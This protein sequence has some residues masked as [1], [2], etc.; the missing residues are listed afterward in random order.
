MQTLGAIVGLAIGALI[1]V[2][3]AANIRLGI[4]LGHAFWAAAISLFLGAL[5]AGAGA[6]LVRAPLPHLLQGV[7]GPWW[8]WLGGAIG[9]VFVMSAIILI[10]R[11]GAAMYLAA[12]IAGQLLAAAFIDAHGWL[13]A[14]PRI[15]SISKAAGL[16]L[17]AI[18]VITLIIGSVA[19]GRDAGAVRAELHLTGGGK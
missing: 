19:S 11:T 1:P 4:S 3:A 9:G 16:M 8:S 13:G 14:T 6:V 5:M 17:I 7:H 10:P 18:G 2:Q 12:V 15:F